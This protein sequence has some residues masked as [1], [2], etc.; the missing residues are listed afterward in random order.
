VTPGAGPAPAARSP[1][2]VNASIGEHQ[3]QL[4]GLNLD[5]M[6]WVLDGMAE[7]FG[8]PAHEL[9]GMDLPA[10]VA[11]SLTKV[12][13]QRPPQ[14]VFYL[15]MLGDELAGMGGLRG[16]GPGLAELKRVYIRPDLQGHGLGQAVLSRLMG[17]AAAFGYTQ[18]CL[19]SAPFMQA[20]QRL[21]RAN[22]FAECP[23]YAG[24]EVPPEFH[25]AWCFMRRALQARSC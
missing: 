19:D 18:L 6:G 2:F 17:D 9:L 24:T 16:I 1:R 21:Y 10:Y 11:S 20:A 5:Y 23:A 13:D 7:A 15:V 25:P 4:S 22:G 14:G 3:A 8:R 12:C